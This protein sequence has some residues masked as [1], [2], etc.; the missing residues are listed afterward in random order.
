MI[1]SPEELYHRM[2]PNI[3]TQKVGG[4]GLRYSGTRQA[5]IAAG[6]AKA[7]QFPGEPGCGIWSTVFPADGERRRM[8]VKRRSPYL[9]YVLVYATPEERAAYE[10]KTY[11]DAKAYA[12]SRSREERKGPA[13]T[14]DSKRPFEGPSRSFEALQAVAQLSPI[15]R[16][17]AGCE[18][19]FIAA[20]SEISAKL[21]RVESAHKE[22]A[23][24][25]DQQLRESAEGLRDS[26][27]IGRAIDDMEAVRASIGAIVSDL[28]RLT[29]GP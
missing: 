29:E 13:G 12:A 20:K 11:A 3:E 7:G 24:D 8:Q 4:Y 28:R 1:E 2:N 6:I 17:L 19:L 27:K 5:L 22:Y 10:A 9:Y 14:S 21:E 15:Q 25:S 18:A 23:D 26:S 16:R